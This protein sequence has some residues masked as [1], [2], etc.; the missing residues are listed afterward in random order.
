MAEKFYIED[1]SDL[2]DLAP[3]ERF[4]EVLIDIDQNKKRTSCLNKQK[5][6]KA[7][8]MKNFRINMKDVIKRYAT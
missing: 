1:H 6:P 2:N 3:I 4:I 8:R 7:L 5:H